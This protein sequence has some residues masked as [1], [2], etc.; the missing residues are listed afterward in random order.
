M[1]LGYKFLKESIIYSLQPILNKVISFFLI[2]LYTTF[3]SPNDFGNLSYILSVGAFFSLIY[4]LGL[5]SSF[6]KF[7]A[8]SNDI[9]TKKIV[10]FNIFLVQLLVGGFILFLVI[11]FKK[12]LKNF[13]DNTGL[14]YLGALVI[15]I[16]FQNSLLL[17]RAKFQAKKYLVFSLLNSALFL[18]LNVLFVAK[19][20]MN[21]KGVIWS[22]FCSF[23]ISSIISFR[24]LK[25]ESKYK[26]DFSLSK[27]MLK[28]SFPLLIGNVAATIISISDRIFLKNYANE[29]ELG[30]Y[31][32]GCKYADLINAVLV[33]PFFLAWNPMRWEIYK[34]SDA[35][36]VYLKFYKY[37]LSLF[38]PIALILV[39]I[40]IPFGYFITVDKT[41]TNGFAITL[42]ISVSYVLNALYYFNSMGLLFTDK[43]KYITIVT[44]VSS[45]ICVLF[46]FLLVPKFGMNGAALST[47]ISYFSMFLLSRYWGEKY[48]PIHRNKKHEIIQITLL[49]IICISTILIYNYIENIFIYS[50]IIF[51]MGMFCLII[52]F[53]IGA[54]SLKELVLIYSEIK[55]KIGSFIDGA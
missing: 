8:E 53:L 44:L 22:Y 34:R 11:I 23:T 2:P 42:M 37:I 3:L 26:I 6:W 38:P 12:N 13:V 48:Y 7:R 24:E 52:S 40:I 45:L 46:N 39:S 27:S 31:S 21:Y 32:Y 30:L 47:I 49:I 15:S 50:L 36:T 25:N 16:F 33:L 41:F 51:M 28:Y 4:E 20:N 1:R 18:L 19:L 55:L 54:I 10:F 17:Y 9:D 43:T 5:T 29:F 35:R 14:L